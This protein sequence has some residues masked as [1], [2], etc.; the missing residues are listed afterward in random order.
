[1]TEYMEDSPTTAR[2]PRWIR[3]RKI[4]AVLDDAGFVD[5]IW[6]DSGKRCLTASLYATSGVS[7]VSR[8]RS[9]LI[10]LAFTRE[11]ALRI[12]SAGNIFVPPG[13]AGDLV[14]FPSPR[15]A[16]LSAIRFHAIAQE[17]EMYR[18]R[19]NGKIFW[20]DWDDDC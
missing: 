15:D 9:I 20:M 13:R 17:N 1:M 8:E 7:P 10:R 11:T 18:M 6:Q 2:V 16:I 14:D 3:W 4:R 5:V 19:K 12:R